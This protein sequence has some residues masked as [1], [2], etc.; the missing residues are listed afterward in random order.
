MKAF[1]DG[2]P[3]VWEAVGNGSYIYRWNINEVISE[4]REGSEEPERTSQW[5]CEEVVVW[6]PVNSQK[7]VQ[8]AISETWPADTES[9]LRNEYDAAE[10]GLYEAAVGAEKQKNYTKFLTDRIVLK[11]QVEKDCVTLGIQ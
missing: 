11:E 3:S 2:K 9:K 7:L 10:L 4:K 8:A 6:Q 1:Y 5:S